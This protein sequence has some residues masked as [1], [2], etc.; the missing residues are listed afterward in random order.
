MVSGQQRT[1]ARH[2]QL[3]RHLARVE[4]VFQR[5]DFRVF[6]N[7]SLLQRI[8][9]LGLGQGN[10]VALFPLG[11]L[12]PPV[13]LLLKL[14]ISHLLEDVG[15]PCRVDLE[16]LAAVGADDFVHVIHQPRLISN[17]LNV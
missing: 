17:R 7:R 2:R 12:Q 3:A 6:G 8:G 11:Q 9:H 14:A 13:Q 4:L 1:R 16:G 10:R 15:I 5:L